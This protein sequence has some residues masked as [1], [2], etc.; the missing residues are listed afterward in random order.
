MFFVSLVNLPQLSLLE[1]QATSYI[2]LI[3]ISLTFN[4]DYCSMFMR[5]REFHLGSVVFRLNLMGKLEAWASRIPYS[6]YLTQSIKTSCLFIKKAYQTISVIRAS[7]L[8][9]LHRTGLF[10]VECITAA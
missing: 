3:I 9:V 8:A 7:S 6:R 4:L 10:D 5:V 2:A 1:F